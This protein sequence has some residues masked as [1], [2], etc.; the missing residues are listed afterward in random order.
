[1]QFLNRLRHILSSP[2]NP[3]RLT[4]IARDEI[5]LET[6]H[7]LPAP[8][9]PELPHPERNPFVNWSSMPVMI[10]RY[11]L[12]DI[13]LDQPLMT[14]LHAGRVIPETAYVQDPEA[15]RALKLRPEDLIRCAPF[16]GITAACVDHWASNYYHWI[17]HTV[18]TLHA[19]SLQKLPVRLVLP[20]H[21]HPWQFETLELFGLTSE[22]HLRLQQGRQYAFRAL[23]YVTFVNGSADFAVSGL[24]R[25]A[26]AHLR[27]AVGTEAGKP[28][29]RLYIERGHSAN[30]HVPNEEALAEALEALGF[31]RIRPETLPLKDQIRLFGEAEMV[32]GM[33]GAGLANIAWCRPGTFV[34]E[35]VPSH[36]VNPCFTA[37][38]AQGDLRYWA[39][40]FETGATRENH[41]DNAAIPLPV[42][43]I[44]NRVRDLLA[45]LPQTLKNSH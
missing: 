28:H 32:M 10:S 39:D 23:D 11:A 34:Y 35:L 22:A 6:C 15:V 13:V 45:R 29:R 4:D 12:R 40:L 25:A 41:T 27:A 5:V 38:A 17:A 7:A 8:N 2:A 18:P 33:L 1:M 16:K 44:L 30:R 20:E 14:L 36:H 43:E 37:M 24:S 42:T 31:E 19:L 3:M 21:M 26:Y 9:V